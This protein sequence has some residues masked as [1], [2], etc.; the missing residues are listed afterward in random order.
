MG[1]DHGYEMH[2]FPCGALWG[3]AT[4]SLSFFFGRGVGGFSWTGNQILCKQEIF[5]KDFPCAWPCCR[6]WMWLSPCEASQK[7]PSLS[8]GHGTE[9][10]TS[11]RKQKRSSKY[12]EG[13]THKTKRTFMHTMIFFLSLTQM[14]KHRVNFHCLARL[15]WA[16]SPPK[17]G[18]VYWG[19]DLNGVSKWCWMN[20]A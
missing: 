13:P 7:C 5:C 1:N 6:K 20:V 4:F 18:N 9:M 12:Q 3:S 19:T 10:R 11:A 17:E 2:L 8:I 15:G 14:A 16:L